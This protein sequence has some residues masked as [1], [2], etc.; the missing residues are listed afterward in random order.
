MN[1]IRNTIKLLRL[2]FSMF[3]LPVSLFSFYY[4][5][6][7]IDYRLLLVLIIW[8]IL[9]FPSSNG[10]N[11]Y[12]DQ[13]EG[14]IGGLAA[15]PKPTKLL[16]HVSNHLDVSAILLSLIV[17]IYFAAFVAV[18]I[19]ASRLYSNK[20]VRLKKYPVGGFLVV[21]FFQGAWV[22]CANV[23]ALSSAT[24]FSNPSV[25]FSAAASSF[26]IG[27]LYPITQIYQHESDR[28]D[29]VETLSMLLGTNGT[30]IFSALMF[31]MATLFI[32]ISFYTTKEINNFWVFNVVLLP[33]TIYFL[34]WA[35]RSSRNKAHINFKNTMT[36]LVLSSLLSNLY[37]LILLVK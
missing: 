2:P 10:Y 31:S 18:Y 33:S 4:I 14:P 17:N 11:S 29:G 6:P 9:V 15:P 8:H 5:K 32:Y 27:T 26:F 25:L 37:F 21:F 35:I 16:L 19:I 30:F 20:K 28:L 22:F 34:S 13:D 23:F 1:N 7:V 36:M 12:N 24:L 3:L